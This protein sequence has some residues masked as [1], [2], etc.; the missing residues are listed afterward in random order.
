MARLPE[1]DAPAYAAGDPWT[2]EDAS[3]LAGQS[4]DVVDA[5]VLRHARATGKHRDPRIPVAA[6]IVT[7]S[8]TTYTIR[9]NYSMPTLTRNGV[10]DV[11]LDLS[12]VTL[13]ADG[14][15][16]KVGCILNDA[17]H[18]GSYKDPTTTA[19]VNIQLVDAAGA[20]ADVSFWVEVYG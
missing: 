16:L 11:K 5:L 19:A 2:A 7:C 17:L 10:G 4:L 8:G 13:T 1:G 20:A 14:W 6:A 18:F 3:M 12:G 9:K 15:G